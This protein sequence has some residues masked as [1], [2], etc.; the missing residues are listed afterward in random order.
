M[1]VDPEDSHGIDDDQKGMKT[2]F[3]S[4]GGLLALVTVLAITI[5]IIAAV[6]GFGS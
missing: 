4:L 1:I 3:F 5:A 2:A 6:T